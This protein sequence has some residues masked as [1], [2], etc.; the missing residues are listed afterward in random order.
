LLFP[1][2]EAEEL[3]CAKQYLEQ[4][5]GR[6]VV[7]VLG[8][9]KGGTDV[10]LYAAK[11]NDVPCVVNLAGRFELQKGVLE[12]LGPEVLERLEREGQVMGGMG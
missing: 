10:L 6:K 4:Q 5:L 9:S 2:S 3:R 12:R 7:G 8:H 1:R 11:Y